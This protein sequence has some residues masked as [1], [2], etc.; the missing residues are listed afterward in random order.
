MATL[1]GIDSG[2][3]GGNCGAASGLYN[4]TAAGCVAITS[5]TATVASVFARASTA[6]ATHLKIAVYDENL[7]LVASGETHSPEVDG[8]VDA[9]L[10]SSVAIVSGKT[11]YLAL[12]GD[13]AYGQCG[14]IDPEYQT[15][16]S[17]AG[18]YSS[19]PAHVAPTTDGES[20]NRALM[21]H[22]DGAGAGLSIP[23]LMRYYQR[24]R[25]Q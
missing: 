25:S 16:A 17:S 9:N 20:N 18:T 12:C 2:T 1:V 13:D 7:D 24:M 21:I 6:N 10:S 8:W 15:R 5:G 11:Y 23:K 19:P 3:S 22:L 4:Y 14:G